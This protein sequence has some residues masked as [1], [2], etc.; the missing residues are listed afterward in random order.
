MAS[1]T[2]GRLIVAPHRVTH[3][4]RDMPPPPGMPSGLTAPPQRAPRGPMEWQGVPPA[5]QFLTPQPWQPAWPAPQVNYA[6]AE[7]LFPECSVCDWSGAT[8]KAAPWGGTQLWGKRV[9][10]RCDAP[11][12]RRSDT[13]DCVEQTASS[14]TAGLGELSTSDKVKGYAV[15]AGIAAAGG[16]IAYALASKSP[17]RTAWTVAGALGGPLLLGAFVWNVAKDIQ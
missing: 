10:T 12:A 16:G 5:Q 14:P 13:F 6:P 3:P 7:A 1:E 8:L 17:N 11:G 15:L 2:K 4:S 9:A